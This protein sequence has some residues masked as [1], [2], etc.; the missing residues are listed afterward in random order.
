M[1][2]ALCAP[3]GLYVCAE[4]DG[5]VTA[6]RMTIA[7]W[8]TWDV[9]K[10]DSNQVGLRSAHGGYLRAEDGGGGEVNTRGTDLSAWQLW[11]LNPHAPATAIAARDRGYLCVDHAL[12]VEA[13]SQ[14]PIAFAVTIVEAD[15]VQLPALH[16]EDKD[17]VT[18]AGDRYVVIGSTELLL[19]VIYDR[20]G[21]DACRPVLQER[22]D[23]GFNNLRVLWQKDIRNRGDKWQMPLDKLRPFLALCNEYEMYVQGCILADCQVVNPNASDQQRRVADVRAATKGIANHLEQLGNEYDKNGFDPA[24]F[25][26]PTDRLAANASNM[27]PIG[28]AKWDYYGFSGRRDLP[29]SIMEY[30]PIEYLYGA[31]DGSGPII[32][33]CDENMK[34][35]TG[36]GECNQPRVYE[37][38]G[39][40]ARAANGGRFHH[41]A[42]TGNQDPNV[43]ISRL[44]NPLERACAA[45]FVEGLRG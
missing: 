36:N 18:A 44:F 1:K 41:W 16:I 14:T 12:L 6:S 23:L 40:E 33:I 31:D 20:Q 29:K 5:S 43:P 25:S 37:R 32:S 2:I 21:P 27:K 42:G 8:E 39:A 34:P 19:G 30:G 15:P 4:A 22:H 45:A 26:R 17:F 28:G 13:T 3:N 10:T 38:C 35:G 24:T 11:K 9:I 7:S